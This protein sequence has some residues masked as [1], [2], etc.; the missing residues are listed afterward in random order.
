MLVARP[1]VHVR[2]YVHTIIEVIV[3][4]LPWSDPLNSAPVYQV[5]DYRGV[6]SYSMSGYLDQIDLNLVPIIGLQFNPKYSVSHRF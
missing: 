6:I 1:L 4:G 3:R 2:R 5:K